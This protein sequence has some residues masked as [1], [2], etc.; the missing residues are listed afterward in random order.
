MLVGHSMGMPVVRQFY[1]KYPEKT[2]ALVSV[3]GALYP[4]APRAAMEPF[5]APLRGANYREIA[6]KM[7]DGMTS[8]QPAAL[9]AEVKA[10]ML[11]TPQHVAVSAM[12][13]MADDAV[14]TED[15]IKVPVL[16]VLARSPFW[17][18]DNEQRFRKLAPE[19]DYRMWEG[20]S[21]FLMMDRPAEFNR[22]L[23]EFISRRKLMK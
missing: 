9:R 6:G 1:R 8:Q 5:L 10:A 16:A 23:S 17:P 18:A 14:W 21:H 15:Q 3:D 13:G 12:E 7:I 11:S 22:E 19:L 4:F 2:L 20:A